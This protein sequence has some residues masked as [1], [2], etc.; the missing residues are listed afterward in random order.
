LTALRIFSIVLPFTAAIVDIIAVI[1]VLAG[2]RD[3]RVAWSFVSFA[4]S[5]TVWSIY[6]GAESI[7]GFTTTY[8]TALYVMVYVFQ[9]MPAAGLYTAVVWSGLQGRRIRLISALGYGVAAGLGVLHFKGLMFAGFINYQWGS[10]SRPGPL[11]PL[12]VMFMLASAAAGV[13][14]CRHALRSL[15]AG[16]VRLRARYALLGLT[17]LAP[18]GFVNFLANYGVPIVPTGSIGN[19]LLVALWTYAAVRHRLMDIDVFIMRVAAALLASIVV[20][21]P[22]AAVVIWVHDLPIGGSSLLVIGCLFL[23]ALVSLMG[24]SRFRSFLEEQVESSLFPTR[25]AARDAIRQLS[26]DLVKLLHRDDLSRAVTATLVEGLGVEGAALYLRKNTSSFE[27]ACTA[28]TIDAPERVEHHRHDAAVGNDGGAV[29]DGD[30]TH[31]SE[32]Q[33]ETCIEIPA[34]GAEIGFLALAPKRSGGAID[35]SDVT[36]LSMVAAQLGVAL[37]NAEYL[38][39]IGRQKAQIEELHKRLEAENVALRAEV[40]SVSQFKEIIGSSPVLQRVLALVDKAAPTE[41]S[42]LITGETGTGKE[43]VARAIH[44]LSPRRNGPLINVNCPAIPAGLAE[45]E[46][47]GHERGAFTGAHEA[48]PGR[49]ELAD[50]GTIF[51]D[52]IGELSMEL[53]V[54]LL[55][56]LQERE[57]QRIGSRKVRKIDVRIVAATNRDIKA[58]MRAGRFRE[59]LFYRLAGMELYVPPLRERTED[60]PMLASFFL[61]RAART[62]QKPVTG[63]AAEALAALGRYNWPGNIRELEHVVERAVLLCAGTVIKPEYL[64]ELA[65]GAERNG[66][67]ASLGVTMRAEKQRRVQAALA[68]TGGNRAAA[69]RLLGMSPSN[70]SRLIKNLGLKA[71]LDLQ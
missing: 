12:L 65:V 60:I 41:V 1:V 55:R 31:A 23:A 11:H 34:N 42:I 46:L 3:R 27:L 7:P 67:T 5:L 62:Y 36:L 35:D 26:A 21:V 66:D 15:E 51:L 19:I 29:S 22:F 13:V 32:H 63:F 64:S 14:L 59:D 40:R 54:K 47:F 18:L 30:G 69:A 33:W 38:D 9:L 52:E 25:H 68:Q 50:G 61:E 17:I 49:F 2:A 70:L 43:L 4:S 28:G 24:F 58:E 44:D 10:I 16:P 56:V 45:S 37:K 71:P 8:A 48:R 57:I 6:V 53:Q 39:K 20:V